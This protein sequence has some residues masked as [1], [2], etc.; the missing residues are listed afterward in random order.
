MKKISFLF[1]LVFAFSFCKNEKPKNTSTLPTLPESFTNEKI[2]VAPTDAFI[3]KYQGKI[4]DKFPIELVLINWSNGNLGGYYFYT[5]Q[6]KTDKNGNQQPQKIELS[7]ELNLNETF[8]LDEFVG[9]DFTGKFTGSLSELS[10]IKGTWS[11]TDSSKSMS[12]TLN[13]II[14]E[15]KTG[16]TGAW[17]RNDAHSPGM[18]ILGNVTDKTVDFG[19]EI[20]NGGK[21][22]F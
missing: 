14:F 7:G 20:F 3:K 13:E 15:D 9:D 21:S 2:P 19:L 18:L 5:D 6:I 11:N 12:Y 17:Y 8:S 10:T 1:L 22:N 4:G 16:W